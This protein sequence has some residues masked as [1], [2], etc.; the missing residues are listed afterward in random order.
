MQ[1]MRSSSD[2]QKRVSGLFAVTA[3][4]AHLEARTRTTTT[5]ARTGA[6]AAAARGAGTV[7]S[8]VKML[9]ELMARVC[10]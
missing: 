7:D 8:C 6:P 5:T 1:E 10:A 4:K 3:R 2:V 9:Q